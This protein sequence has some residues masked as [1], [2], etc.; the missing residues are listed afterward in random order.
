MNNG[1]TSVLPF[2]KMRT[3]GGRDKSCLRACVLLLFVIL[4]L[5]FI[6]GYRRGARFAKYATEE[7]FVLR[8]DERIIANPDSLMYYARL[9]YLEEN[10]KALAITGAAAYY[11]LGDQSAQD[12]LPLVST[13]EGAIMLLRAVELGDMDAVWIIKCLVYQRLWT[14]SV[15][16]EVHQYFNLYY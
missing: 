2:C 7:Y 14:H 5:F 8:C 16:D 10:P 6:K 11:F 3:G 15:P 9:A 13:D 1:R 4:S 12:S